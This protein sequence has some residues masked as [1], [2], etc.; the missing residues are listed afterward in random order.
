MLNGIAIAV[1]VVDHI[2]A[3]TAVVDAFRRGERE[4][5]TPASSPLLRARSARPRCSGSTRCSREGPKNLDASGLQQSYGDHNRLLMLG[6]DRLVG[7]DLQWLRTRVNDDTA[8]ADTDLRSVL[9]AVAGLDLS[10]DDLVA[11]WLAAALHDCGM[12]CGRGAYVDVEDGI[13]ISR[14]IVE[15]LCP[16]PLQELAYF[17]LHHHDYIKDVFLGEVPTEIVADA[18]AELTAAV[19]L[20]RNRVGAF[21]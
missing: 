13:V 21:P 19:A 16:A 14:D 1:A 3:I 9:D 4:A 17:A 6:L 7:G 8:V 11:L 20:T 10:R 12:L 15:A 18:L 5:L 2:D